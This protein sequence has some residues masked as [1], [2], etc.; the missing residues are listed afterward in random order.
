MLGGKG[1]GLMAAAIMVS[2]FGCINGM[3]LAGARVYY[4]MA[5]D[6]L[7]FPSVGKIHPKYHTPA[8]SLLVQAVW[9]AIL[10]LTGSYNELLDYVIFAVVLFYIL[11][12]RRHLPAAADAPGCA[13]A[14]SGLGL[15]CP[16]PAVYRFRLVCG[17]SFADPQNVAKFRRIKY[18]R[19][20]HSG[21][22]FLATVGGPR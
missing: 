10:T 5:K 4:A 3:V 19:H 9:A 12:I 21:L 18:R 22:L 13:A 7:F 1:A 8:V 2:T 6:G 17:V 16:S 11:T 20:R 15:P 14:L